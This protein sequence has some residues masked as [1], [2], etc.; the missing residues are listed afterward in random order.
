M[1]IRKW[2]M[3]Q[4]IF[5]GDLEKEIS[6]LDGVVNLIDLRCYNKVGDG[7]SDT[8]ITQQLVENTDVVT[9]NNQ[10]DL[11]ASE[12]TLFADTGTMFEIK[13]SNDVVVNIRER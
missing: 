2:Q 10:L 13:Y 12:K 4:D 8:K 1:D 5:I 9:S 3:G 7:Y 6:K 11:Q